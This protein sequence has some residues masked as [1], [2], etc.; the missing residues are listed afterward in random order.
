MTSPLLPQIGVDPPERGDAARNRRLLLDAA[1][2]LVAERG[3]DAVTMDAVA[4][5]AG[6]GKGTVF[7][8]FGSRSGLMHALLDHTERELQQSFM[9]GPPPLGPGADPIDRLIA[10]GHARIAIVEVQGEVQRAAENSLEF[11]FAA[12]ARAVSV[13]HVVSLL[14]AAGVH[15]DH[16]LLACSLLAPIE[17]TLVLHELRDLGMSV[18]RLGDAWEDLIRRVTRC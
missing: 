18:E 17:A 14:R 9:F 5:K 12:P 4:C 8:R 10:F 15:G 1:A 3:V 7:R 6:V 11:R 16:E 2:L 13:R